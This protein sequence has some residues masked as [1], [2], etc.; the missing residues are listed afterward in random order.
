VH[1]QRC[2]SKQG[3]R[4]RP[5]HQQERSLARLSGVGGGIRRPGSA[6]GASYRIWVRSK[7]VI[8]PSSLRNHP[9][10]GNVVTL[11]TASEAWLSYLEHDKQRA[12]TTLGDYRRTCKNQFGP[13]SARTHP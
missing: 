11:K 5:C 7:A 10:T 1:W 6:P 13:R 9:I 12:S 2:P 8:L 4:R 3:L